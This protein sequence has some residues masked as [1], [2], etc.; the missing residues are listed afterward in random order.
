[1]SLKLALVQMDIAWHDRASNHSKA[2]DFIAQACDKGA[3]IVVL[4]EMF[5]T[6]FSMETELTA[7]TLSGETPSF[8]RAKAEEYGIWLIGGFALQ[9]DGGKP[10]NVALAV[11]PRGKDMA[12]YSKIHRIA[13]LEED[14]HYDAGSLPVSF[15]LAGIRSACLICYDLRFPELFRCVAD[16]CGLVIVIASWPA[17]RQAHW[18]VLLKARAVENQFYVAGVNRVG[19]GNGLDFTGGSAILDPLGETLAHAGD[20][21]RLIMAEIQPE[22]P[23][24]VR[25]DLPFLRDRQKHLFEKAGSVN[26]ARDSN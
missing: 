11:N 13:L 25:R 21:E 26:P 19:H 15:D 9:K 24:R 6:G 1:M 22:H 18:D 20:E 8:L 5:S 23:T 17:S 14:R 12:L 7:E 16:S 4:P 2:G 10:H 3:E